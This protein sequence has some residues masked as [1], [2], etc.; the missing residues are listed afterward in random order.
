MI[1]VVNK[2]YK[3]PASTKTMNEWCY[4]FPLHYNGNIYMENKRTDTQTGLGL[5]PHW[6][7][8]AVD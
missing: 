6:P 5:R 1:L 8:Y 4:K 3:D 2:R 7:L